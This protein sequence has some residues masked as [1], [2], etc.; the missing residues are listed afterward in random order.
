MAD[1]CRWPRLG[2]EEVLPEEFASK[3]LESPWLVQE[4][5]E[6]AGEKWNKNCGA[7]YASADD[8]RRPDPELQRPHPTPTMPQHNPS[9]KMRALCLLGSACSRGRRESGLTYQVH[10][11]SLQGS[12]EQA[13]GA[14]GAR[15][16]R[17]RV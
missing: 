3:S 10:K 1:L 11:V 7:C 12:L 14:R 6:E 2:T 17:E 5:P 8:G 13:N 15:R 9:K 4:S 16:E